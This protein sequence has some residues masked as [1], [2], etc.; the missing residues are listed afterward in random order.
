MSEDGM[1]V[2][3]VVKNL[4]EFNCNISNCIVFR[5]VAGVKAIASSLVYGAIF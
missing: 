3:L 4:R 1:G 2:L 5:D